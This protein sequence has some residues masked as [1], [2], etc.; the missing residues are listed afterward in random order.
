[1]SARQLTYLA[2]VTDAGEVRAPKRMRA[3]IV[4]AFR[5]KEIEFVVRRKRRHRTNAQ[6]AYYWAVV[7]PYVLRG[8]ADLGNDLSEN[9]P[10]DLAQVHEFLK[11]R[12]IPGR[13]IADA[14]GEVHQ[15]PPTTTTLNVADMM[16]YI[17][18]IQ[19]FAAEY[20]NITIP[21]AGEQ[22]ELFT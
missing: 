15:L 9:N 1:M 11:H 12:F 22:T 13:E 17:S 21:E 2:R 10:D 6:N 4:A 20:L 18:K 16:D 19:Q 7:V 8:F 3:E 5:G 14:N